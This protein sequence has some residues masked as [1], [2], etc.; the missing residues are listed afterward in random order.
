MSGSVTA[1]PAPCRI[2]WVIVALKRDEA[3][4]RGSPVRNSLTLVVRLVE[5]LAPVQKSQSNPMRLLAL[6][7]CSSPAPV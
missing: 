3:A 1:M 5:S 7:S 4:L 2:G 6:T